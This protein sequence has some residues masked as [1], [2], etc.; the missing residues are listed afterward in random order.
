MSE[1]SK[2]RGGVP[3]AMIYGTPITGFSPQSYEQA[4]RGK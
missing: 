1:L 3:F 2:G 4:L